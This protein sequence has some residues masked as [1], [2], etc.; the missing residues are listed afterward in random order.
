[1]YKYT[2]KSST[3]AYSTLRF[4]RYGCNKREGD[5]I[6]KKL[7]RVLINDVALHGLGR[8][9]SVFEP[10]GCSDHLRCMIHFDI[11][12]KQKKRKPFKFTNVIATMDEFLPTVEEYWRG[13]DQLFH[14]TSAL[15]RLGKKLKGLKHAFEV[16]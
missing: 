6:C 9:Y 16:S 12:D 3:G 15:Y 10:G 13:T 11:E 1:M 14:S 5:L 2:M 7:D 4:I 8:A